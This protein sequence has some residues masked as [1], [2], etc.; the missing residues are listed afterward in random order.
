MESAHRAKMSFGIS[1][2]GHSGGVRESGTGKA[3]VC[4]TSTGGRSGTPEIGS[5]LPELVSETPG[6]S[7]LRHAGPSVR[8]SL[9]LAVEPRIL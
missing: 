6:S 1:G 4:A 2:L 7:L 9:E 3:T 5:C 8:A